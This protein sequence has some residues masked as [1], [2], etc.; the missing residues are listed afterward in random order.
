MAEET[1]VSELLESEHRRIGDDLESFRRSLDRGEV[2]ATAF[3]RAAS[4]LQRHIYLEEDILFPKVEPLGLAGPASVMAMEHGEISGNLLAIQD[5]IR[6][7]AD[8]A[9][10]QEL[11]TTLTTVLDGHNLK[12]ERILY[13]AADRLLAESGD[14]DILQTLKDADLPSGWKCRA[15]R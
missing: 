9:L 4:V 1:T 6:Q 8:P 3:E 5:G 10:L 12:E 7:G 14:S 15:L 2:E 11:F 13:P